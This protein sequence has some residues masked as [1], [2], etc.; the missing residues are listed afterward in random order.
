[1]DLTN[2]GTTIGEVAP[3]PAMPAIGDDKTPVDLDE[4]TLNMKGGA[5]PRRHD[6][7]DEGSDMAEDDDAESTASAPIAGDAKGQGT[8]EEEKELPPHACA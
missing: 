7:D 3:A 2:L 5:R 1:M 8:V 6:D 4:S